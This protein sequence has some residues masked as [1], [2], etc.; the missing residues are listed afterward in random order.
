M[1]PVLI[2]LMAIS[3]ALYHTA[4]TKDN[5]APST[6]TSCTNNG[7]DVMSYS[8][9][10]VPILTTYC[11]DPAFGD[12]HFPGSALTVDLTTYNAMKSEVELGNFEF[13]VLGSSASMP[14]VITLG[15][16][17]LTSCDKEKLQLW[18][19]QGYPDN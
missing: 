17:L 7:M 18:I 14:K 16:A 15:P 8:L 9:D 2:I 6:D 12:C 4:C 13:Y 5:A 1:K 11:T 3:F 10:V 19:D